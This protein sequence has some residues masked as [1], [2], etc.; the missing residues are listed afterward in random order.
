MAI[1]CY[2]QDY[3]LMSRIA[4]AA[5]EKEAGLPTKTGHAVG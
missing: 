2:S 4:R 3:E 5:E 1:R